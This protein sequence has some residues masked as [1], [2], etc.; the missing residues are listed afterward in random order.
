MRILVVEDDDSLRK[1]I[2]KRLE[3]EYYSV[4]STDNGSDALDYIDAGSYDCVLLDWMLPQVSGM[5]IL[6]H[7]RKQQLS[8]PALILTAR[9]SVQDRVTGLDT[10][11]DDYLTKPFSLDELS[12]RVRALLRRGIPDKNP[13][14]QLS[15]LSMD[16][17]ARRVFRGEQEIELTSKEYALL[18]YMMRHIGQ[19]L[20]R[21]Q[22]IEHV[23]NFDFEYDSNIVDVYMRYLRRKIDTPFSSNLIQTIRGHGYTLRETEETP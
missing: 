21:D 2:V 23:W 17:A 3:Q 6:T 9:D 22:L 14:L 11:A 18:E 4:D 15:D 13:I 5:E 16:V 12:A 8:T 7:M 19:V 1:I 20:T 10:G